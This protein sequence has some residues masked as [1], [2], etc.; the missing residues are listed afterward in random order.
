M[1]LCLGTVQFGMDYGVQGAHRQSYES[2]DEI[3]EYAIKAGITQFDSAAVYGDAEDVVGHYIRH[4]GYGA[5]R[6]RVVSKLA[7]GTL[8]GLPEN[9]WGKVAIRQAKKSIDSLG[10]EKLQGFLFHNATYIYNREAV[11]ALD[12]VK[13][14]GLA[15]KIGV[16]IYS[17]A[18]AMKAL[19]YDEI[20]AIQIP[21]NL[22]DH[23]L[24]NSGFFEETQKRDITVYARS[25]LLQGLAVM[26]PS[27][28]PTNMKFAENYIYCLEE[29][30]KKYQVSR[31]K[32]AIGYVNHHVGIDYIVF[33][34]DNL[35]QLKEYV[36]TVDE[37]LPDGLIEE[38]KDR[39]DDVDEKLVN[40]TLWR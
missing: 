6:I 11:R 14:E 35:E 2:I 12:E 32:A 7:A 16:S 24:D 36:L 8:D 28:L 17:P 26:D 39:F 40:P 30:C 15:K 4:K 29:I 22:F 21:Y 1:K 5:N 27:K 18:E 25:T 34:V 19:E 33:G 23:R 20:D 37:C 38:I 31:L 3:I 10:V 13:K 9:M